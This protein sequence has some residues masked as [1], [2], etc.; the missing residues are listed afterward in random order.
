MHL[1]RHHGV[2]APH[3]RLRAAVTPAGRGPVRNTSH[4]AMSR[5]QRLKRAFGI[6]I[7]TCARCHGRQRVIAG[8]EDPA[9]ITRI[10]AHLDRAPGT[11]EPVPLAARAP[12]LQGTL[13]QPPCVG[14]PIETRTCTAIAV[15]RRAKSHPVRLIAE[16]M[17][18]SGARTK[19]EAVEDSLRLMVQLKRQERIRRARGKLKWTGDLDAMRRD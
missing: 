11:A 2:F 19:R 6:E 13:L 16:A 1:T 4:V 10:L 8:I 18:L 3:R 12:P 9:V 17:K 7:D 14:N 5:A 15:A